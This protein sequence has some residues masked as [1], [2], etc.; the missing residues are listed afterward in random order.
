MAMDMNTDP[1]SYARL[2]KWTS[3]LSLSL[4]LSL[5]LRFEP[6]YELPMGMSELRALVQS[7]LGSHA[8]PVEH[9]R[10]ARRAVPRHLF[11]SQSWL[12]KLVPLLEWLKHHWSAQQLA[13]SSNVMHVDA[14]VHLQLCCTCRRPIRI[15]KKQAWQA[16]SKKS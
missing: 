15:A 7:R 8:L 4:S 2:A 12:T 6:Y 3:A 11:W 5:S 14:C 10:F 9:G 13:E 1:S 16:H